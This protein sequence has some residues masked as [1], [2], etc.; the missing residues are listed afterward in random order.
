MN[1]RANIAFLQKVLSPLSPL[2][3]GVTALRAL[4]YD[5][6]VLPSKKLPKPVLSVGNLTTGGTGKTPLVIEI[7]LRLSAEGLRPVVLSRGYKGN[8]DSPVNFVSDTDRVLMDA[9]EAGDEPVL[10]ARK[11]PGI[12]VLTARQ[13]YRGGMA[14][15]ERFGV[16]LF[17]LDD[18]FQHLPLQRDVNILLVDGVT[19]FGAERC[20]PGGDLREGPSAL[21]R[22]D[23]I[24]LTGHPIEKWRKRI[25]GLA[26]RADLHNVRFQATGV[27]DLSSGKELPLTF[28]EGKKLFAFAGI[29][30]PERFYHALEHAGVVLQG[31]QSFR[32]HY[33]FRPSDLYA[34]IE[35][36]TEQGA[37]GLITTE[38]DAVR[39]ASLPQELPFYTLQLGITMDNMDNFLREI[40]QRIQNPT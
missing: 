2:Y 28:L 4:L 40:R 21:R 37:E 18:G 15:L 34:L 31:R 23:M 38:K 12:P 13:R 25:E 20:L 7:A 19:P 11:L 35:K 39:I 9:A 6:K 14:A 30:R 5:K 32:D 3:Q 33:L 1:G 10:M 16:D 27:V 24:I 29:A 8:A 22:A 17:V 36:A 26:P